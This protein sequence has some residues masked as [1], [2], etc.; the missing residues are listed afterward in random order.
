VVVLEL[1]EKIAEGPPAEVWADARVMD[2][3]LGMVA[4]A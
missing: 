4:D 1:G 2:A 3:Y